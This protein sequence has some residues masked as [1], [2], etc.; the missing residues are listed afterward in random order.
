M[1]IERLV[2]DDRVV[3]RGRSYERETLEPS[4]PPPRPVDDRTR[5]RKTDVSFGLAGRIVCTAIVLIP[6][7]RLLATGSLFWLLA[8][9]ACVP[10]GAWWL[11]ETWR[12]T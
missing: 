10:F 2:D 5:W 12:K 1:T 9:V 4:P 11:R 3:V 6:L 7:W 8:S